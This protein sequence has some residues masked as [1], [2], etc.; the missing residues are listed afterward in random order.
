MEHDLYLEEDWIASPLGD[1]S[2]NVFTFTFSCIPEP[3]SSLIQMF[4]K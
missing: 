1:L 2:V 4:Y 3:K